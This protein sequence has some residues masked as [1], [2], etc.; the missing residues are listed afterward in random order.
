MASKTPLEQ[1][2]TA[3][4]IQPGDVLLF[5]PG[6][7]NAQSSAIGHTGM[8]ISSQLF[9]QSSGQGIALARWDTGYYKDRLAFGKSVL[10]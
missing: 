1:R 7:V 10:P 6:G 2:L 4:L 8:A 5:G 3:D 9:I